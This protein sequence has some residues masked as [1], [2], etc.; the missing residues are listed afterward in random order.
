[1]SP[2]RGSV[3]LTCRSPADRATRPT[4]ETC[5]RAFVDSLPAMR[6][7]RVCGKRPCF[8]SRMRR[9]RPH[10]HGAVDVAAQRLARGSPAAIRPH[11]R[12]LAAD[13]ATI[14]YGKSTGP[15]GR[16]GL[17][18]ESLPDARLHIVRHPAAT[19][20]VLRGEAAARFD[21]NAAAADFPTHEMPSRDGLR[22]GDGLTLDRFRDMPAVE[23]PAWRW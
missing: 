14:D 4:Y 7:D 9:V 11:R 23:R 10:R 21:H 1:M 12:S 6:A 13:R 15:L 8:R 20:P 17:M 3:W 5:L 18:L 22:S 16:L 2:T 19:W